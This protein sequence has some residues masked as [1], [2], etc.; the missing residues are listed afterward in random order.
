MT[1][2]LLIKKSI[3]E[4]QIYLISAIA[5]ET[6]ITV[7]RGCACRAEADG[8]VRT[9]IRAQAE[10]IIPDNTKRRTCARIAC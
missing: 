10:R 2:E 9:L 3:P 1:N 4:D 7:K 6:H 5:G 8:D